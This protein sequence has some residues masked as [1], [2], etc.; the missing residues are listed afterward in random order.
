M[1][2]ASEHHRPGEPPP[3]RDEAADTPLWLPVV[4]LCLLLL[5]A[6]A[7]ISAVGERRRRL[8]LVRR[9][10]R[11]GDHRRG[12]G[13]RRA[14]A[15]RGV[16]LPAG[17]SERHAPNEQNAVRS[18]R[19]A[20]E[21]PLGVG[22]EPPR[23]ASSGIV[24][25]YGVSCVYGPRRTRKRRAHAMAVATRRCSLALRERR[26]VVVEGSRSRS[27]ASRERR[28]AVAVAARSRC[29]R[30]IGWWRGR[31]RRSLALPERRGVVVA[32]SR[33]LLAR[34]ATDGL[35]EVAARS[36]CER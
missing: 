32:G 24:G 28:R 6:F 20:D 1:A 34:A 31:G 33:S 36:R 27:L 25:S 4:G 13:C 35:V 12:A 10:R 17:G 19:A 29:E 26:G 30:A 5:G 15:G 2:E 23:L 8:L 11:G 7:V 22:G 9:G 21:A 3:I 16:A 14:G 18:V